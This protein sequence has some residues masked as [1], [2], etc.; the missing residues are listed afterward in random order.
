MA[1]ALLFSANYHKETA[2]SVAIS[3]VRGRQ[4]LA[5]VQ[6]HLR[7]HRAVEREVQVHDHKGVLHRFMIWWQQPEPNIT[8]LGIS[9]TVLPRNNAISALVRHVTFKGD[10]LVMK[11]GRRDRYIHLSG[12]RECDL[13]KKAV[14]M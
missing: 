7:D 14:R 6:E 4:P 9:A 8:T 13:A 2:V 5:I 10:L 3:R 1:R 11:S 12:A